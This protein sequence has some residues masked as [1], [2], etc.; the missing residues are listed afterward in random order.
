MAVILF[1]VV[2]GL[3]ATMDTFAPKSA[4][5]NVDLPTFGV[6]IIDMKPQ[7]VFLSAGKLVEDVEFERAFVLLELFSVDFMRVPRAIYSIP[8]MR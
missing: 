8:L 2:L 6:P 7:R 5:S 3:G 4:F 1:R